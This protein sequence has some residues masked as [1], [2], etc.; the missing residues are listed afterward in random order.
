MR[1][2][3][4]LFSIAVLS[5]AASVTSAEG[6]PVAGEF[7]VGAE[8]AGPG[9]DNAKFR[10]YWFNPR[11]PAG[12]QFALTPALSLTAEPFPG[13]YLD[14]S[15]DGRTALDVAESLDGRISAA[16][17][18]YGTYRFDA[19][20]RRIG[21]SFVYGAKTLYSGVGTNTLTLDDAIQYKLQNSTSSNNAADGL[22]EVAGGTSSVYAAGMSEV[23]LGLRRDRVNVR[24]DWNLPAS[25]SAGVNLDG[26]HRKGTRPFGGGFGFGNAIELPEPIDYQTVN[27]TARADWMGRVPVHEGLPA[28]ARLSA[29]RSTFDDKSLGFDY[30]NP[31]RYTNTTT[32]SGYSANYAAGAAVGRHALPP[33]N[34]ADSLGLAL[35]VTLP[36]HLRADGSAHRSV[37]TQNVPFL[38]Q[39]TN[40]T[41]QPPA[42]PR[43]SLEGEIVKSLFAGSLSAR[44]V[45]RYDV[46]A[47]YR[48]L[49]HDNRTEEFVTPQMSQLDV[50]QQGSATPHN[51]S[52]IEREV[53]LEQE[54]EVSHRST[55]GL[56]LMH[57]LETFKNGSADREQENRAVLSFDTREL[58]WAMI[59]VSGEHGVRDADYPD[60]SGTVYSG[61]E[62]PWMRKYYAA[63]RDR[64]QVV[65]MISVLPMENLTLSLEQVAGRDRYPASEFGLRNASRTLTSLGLDY[66]VSEEV[67]FST[68]ASQERTFSSQRSRQWAMRNRT[69]G[70]L[71][72]GDPY[73][74]FGGIEDYSNWT[75]EATDVVRTLGAATDVALVPQKLS[76]RMEGQYTENEGAVDMDS[77]VNTSP[78][79][80]AFDTNPFIPQDFPRVDSAR[81]G[82][83]DTSLRYVLTVPGLFKTA[84]AVLGYRYDVWRISGFQYEGY[85][86][87][88]KTISGGYNGLLSMDTLPKDYAVHSAYLKL[89]T[90][91]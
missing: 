42:L 5:A 1:I 35:G 20:Y 64:S 69:T 17:G 52:F 11:T 26:E 49:E 61:G 23:D 8:V 65:A 44:P 91:F 38:P 82:S 89:T 75:A 74:Q 3:T 83:F 24:F 67:T 32:A 9:A 10:E 85:E 28:Y 63:S 43:E 48:Y 84:I 40:P 34:N 2:L 31:F 36:W 12:S 53:A 57:I 47:E 22:A 33:D 60:Y 16:V 18:K 73:D 6:L 79:A 25:F 56:K 45:E 14:V 62:L 54:I 71:P 70:V 81:G 55:I 72:V 78:S 46:K 19:D 4:K 76:W 59:R 21:H 80:T 58:D 87:V 37:I 90:A 41:M 68:F 30:D 29:G 88:G 86:S 51:V 15:V 66:T 13:G 39:S 7:S 77:P 50:A 27:L